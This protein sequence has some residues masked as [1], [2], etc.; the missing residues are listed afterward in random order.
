MPVAE[1]E[2]QRTIR[3]LQMMFKEGYEHKAK[4]EKQISEC[5]Q[6]IRT[7]RANSQSALKYAAKFKQPKVVE[8]IN[9]IKSSG[10]SPQTLDDPMLVELKQSLVPLFEQ[11]DQVNT[12]AFSFFK[13]KQLSN[14]QNRVLTR[15]DDFKSLS[16]DDERISEAFSKAA[17][18]I[19]EA[20]LERVKLA[21]EIEN[22]TNRVLKKRRTIRYTILTIV[23]GCGG[24]FFALKENNPQLLEQYMGFFNK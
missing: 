10:Q 23:I 15:N 24:L 2:D 3:E 4:S 1:R 16:E 6:S 7:F 21:Q 19:K 12:Q 20:H 9:A 17:N 14:Y 13:S 11:C 22:E 5:E 8:K 18:P